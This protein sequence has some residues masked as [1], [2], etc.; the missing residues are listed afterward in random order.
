LPAPLSQL[1]AARHLRGQA[2][3][4]KGNHWVG[5]GALLRAVPTLPAPLSTLP[6]CGAGYRMWHSIHLSPP[7]IT[8]CTPL[9]ASGERE[10][11]AQRYV[12]SSIQP[13]R[14]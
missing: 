9:M 11:W 4:V 6:A 2:P 8:A 7:A 14:I 10:K 12:Q 13:R 5:T 1:C 3:S